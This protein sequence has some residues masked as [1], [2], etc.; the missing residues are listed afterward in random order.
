MHK[1]KVEPLRG[2]VNESGCSHDKQDCQAH[3]AVIAITDG[4]GQGVVVLSNMLR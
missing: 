2:C 1:K 3:S 4:I